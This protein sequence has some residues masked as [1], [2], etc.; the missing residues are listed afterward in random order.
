[1]RTEKLGVILIAVAF[2]LVVIFSSV[3]LFSLKKVDVN[4]SVS[5][6]MNSEQIQKTLDGYLGENLLF[7]NESVIYESL[8][9]NP[10]VEIVS[11]KKDYPNVLHVEINERREVFLVHSGEKYFATTD[12]GFVLRE[13][14]KS[15]FELS[16][17]KILLNFD[18]VTL[19]NIVVG[20]TLS[21]DN[22][23]VLSTVIEMAKS[24]NLTDC[25]KRITVKALSGIREYDATFETYSGVKMTVEDVLV[26]GVDK[27]INAFN[28]YD[29]ILTDYQ[30]ADGEI[31][32]YVME[33]GAFRVTYNQQEV[34]TSGN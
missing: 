9:D 27:T 10:Y 20:Q 8:K 5:E 17:D 15:E 19:T 28:A 23:D 31:Q 30:K 32:S 26:S 7:F 12:E 4:F 33:N 3:G 21:C 13:L 29:D 25:I 22:V 24:V 2:M 6:N 1:M 34:W 14:S 18:G 11:V 16:R